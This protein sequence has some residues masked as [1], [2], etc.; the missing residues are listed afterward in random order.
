MTRLWWVRHGPTHAKT[1]VGWSDLP[2]DLSDTAAVAR[3]SRALPDVPV[4]A[5]DLA[6]AAATA[7]AIAGPRPRLPAE[8]DLREMHF[9]AW[10]LR[11]HAEIEAQDPIRLRAI[12]EE[13]GAVRPPGGE[14]WDDLTARVNAAADRL[15]ARHGDLIVVAHF[16]PILAQIQRARG[17]TAY[18][19]FGHR[20][21]NLSVT[22]LCLDGAWRVEGINRVY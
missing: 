6:R 2:A 5:S 18:E 3:L 8:P 11:A 4:V 1:M 13:P 19:A 12:F 22:C 10:E 15:A 21:D 9:G 17:L 20:I 16:G 7:D 14:S